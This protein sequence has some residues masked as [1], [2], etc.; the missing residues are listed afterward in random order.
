MPAIEQKRNFY[1]CCFLCLLCIVI[2]FQ[3]YFLGPKNFWNGTYTHYNNYIIFKNSFHHLRENVNLYSFYPKEYADLFKYSPTFALAMGVFYVLPD[4]AGLLAWNLL[5][6]FTLFCA[7]SK[8]KFQS[9]KVLI[10]VLLYVLMELILSTQN[11]Q[12]NALVAG[13][14]IM[15]FNAFENRKTF[16]ASLFLAVGVFIKIYSLIGFLLLLLYPQKAKSILYVA[17]N[18]LILFILPLIIISPDQLVLQYANWWQLIQADA[19]ESTGMSMYAFVNLLSVSN[20]A[21]MISLIAGFA[22]LSLPFLLRITMNSYR[23]RISMLAML[24]LWMVVFNPKA[25]SPTYIIVMTG[26]ALWCWSGHMYRVKKVLAALALFFT[27]LWFT[28]LIPKAIKTC[29]IDAQF[30]KPLFPCIILFILFYELVF[31]NRNSSRSFVSNPENDNG[32]I[33]QQ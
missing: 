23:E 1:L 27:S 5:N 13:L 18:C 4:W 28:D 21:R 2:S 33:N 30:V 15:A 31:S 8:M 17:V 6:V 10:F 32:Q 14:I 22:L 7:L 25:E 9:E 20:A 16:F 11:A 26:I 12:S 24:L 3:Q 29:F 19:G